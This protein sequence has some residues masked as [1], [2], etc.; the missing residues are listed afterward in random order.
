MDQSWPAGVCGGVFPRDD[1]RGALDHSLHLKRG[2][3]SSSEGRL[4][5]AERSMQHHDVTGDQVPTH[6]R[7]Q[8]LHL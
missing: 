6:C 1:K 2:A 5:G 3:D 4:A 8:R 7:S